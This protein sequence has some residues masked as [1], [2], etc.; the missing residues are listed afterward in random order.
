MQ[1]IDH[2]RLRLEPPAHGWLPFRLEIGDVVV[3]DKAS[4]VLNDP[5]K[6]LLDLRRF[7]D[8]SGWGALRVC[9]W[10][11]PDGYLL[12]TSAR[13]DES[14][15]VIRLGHAPDLIPPSRTGE[16][17]TMLEGSVAREV[18]GPA[19]REGLAGLL[20]GPGAE[21]LD[22][23]RR[24]GRSRA[25]AVLSACHVTERGARS[26]ETRSP[27]STASSTGENPR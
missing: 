8:E 5:V 22:G 24:G 15:I 26:L 11:E 2:V 7:A 21:A 20:E 3:E 9:L 17:Q 13:R 18:L 1:T 14:S 6:E 19:L 16:V 10:L 23:W 12:D 25:T 4:R 27:T